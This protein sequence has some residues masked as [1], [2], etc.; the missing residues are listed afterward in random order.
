M[1][2][3]LRKYFK[4][5]EVARR[6]LPLF[7][8]VIDKAAVNGVQKHGREEYLGILE[9]AKLINLSVFSSIVDIASG[10]GVTQSAVWPILQKFPDCGGLCVEVDPGSFSN[11]ATIYTKFPHVALARLKVT[12]MMVSELFSA[13]EV[14]KAFD[15]LNLDIDSFD[16]PVLEAVLR[17]HWQPSILSMEINEKF[18]PSIY[19]SVNYNPE[20]AWDGGHFYGCSISAAAELLAEFDYEPIDLRGNNLIAVPRNRIPTRWEKRSISQLYDD[21]YLTLRREAGH[22]AWNANVDHWQDMPSHSLLGEI[23]KFFAQ[24][25]EDSY[26]LNAGN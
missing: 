1:I 25:S 4:N 7:T 17:D 8:N 12:P 23:R 15:L 24:Y 26:E 2:N 22:F 11:L 21:G 10:D 3:F 18:P 5:R 20:F 19:F 9:A 13:S 16:L 6:F 14:P